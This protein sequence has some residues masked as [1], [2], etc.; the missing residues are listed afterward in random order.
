MTRQ[1]GHLNGSKNK[2]GVEG[3]MKTGAQGQRASVFPLKMFNIIVKATSLKA[4]YI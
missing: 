3:Q 1:P 2:N 4:L